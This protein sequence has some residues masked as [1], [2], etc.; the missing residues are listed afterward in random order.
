MKKVVLIGDSIR[1]GYQ[2]TVE[3]ELAGTTQIV[4]PPENCSDTGK[5]ILNLDEWVITQKPDLVHINAGLH[6]LKR[7]RDADGPLHTIE[8]YETNLR[9]ILSRVKADTAAQIIWATT[10]PVNEKVHSEVKGFERM[11]ADVDRYN[12]AALKI[13][14]EMDLPVN[15]LFSFVTT[16]GRDEMLRPD[17]VHFR[18]EAYEV[19]GN[20][21]ASVIRNAI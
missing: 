13:V 12:A 5:I 16:K 14:R 15:D 7:F 21:V 1:M 8:Q 19:I 3:S 20:E 9:E 10:T 6:D 4:S 18:P 2:P 17:G 11:E